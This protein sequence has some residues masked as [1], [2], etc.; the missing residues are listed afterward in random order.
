MI[1][2]AAGGRYKIADSQ[3]TTKVATLSG[4]LD[5]Q[6]NPIVELAADTGASTQLWQLDK[7]GIVYLH[8]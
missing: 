8:G 6:G 5:A 1:E 4:D 7:L 3:D 2:P